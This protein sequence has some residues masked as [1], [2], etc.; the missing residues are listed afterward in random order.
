MIDDRINQP[1]FHILTSGDRL[2]KVGARRYIYKKK[3]YSLLVKKEQNSEWSQWN[4]YFG[5]FTKDYIITIATKLHLNTTDM[6][7]THVPATWPWL[8]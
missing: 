2:S 8:I 4:V 5:V 6:L 3:F 1:V 7:N